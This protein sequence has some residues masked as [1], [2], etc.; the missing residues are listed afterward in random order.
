LTPLC[1]RATRFRIRS[2]RKVRARE[3]QF[4]PTNPKLF[5]N[6]SGGNPRIRAGELGCD[7]RTSAQCTVGD[8]HAQLCESGTLHRSEGRQPRNGCFVRTG[9]YCDCEHMSASDRHYFV[10]IRVNSHA[11]ACSYPFLMRV[12]VLARAIGSLRRRSPCACPPQPLPDRFSWP[13][14]RQRFRAYC[15]NVEPHCARYTTMR[16]R[17]DF[18]CQVARLSE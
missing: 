14:S 1:Q 16:T 18:S 5:T 10:Y 7:G 4:S 11:C 8:L 6:K 9:L 2:V 3:N 12:E 15:N 17:E 13:R